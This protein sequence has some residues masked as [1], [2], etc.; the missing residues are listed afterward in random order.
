MS[1]RRLFHNSPTAAAANGTI[2]NPSDVA[3]HPTK[4]YGRTIKRHEGAPI[5]DHRNKWETARNVKVIVKN[6]TPI[7]YPGYGRIITMDSGIYPKQKTYIVA[8]CDFPSCTCEDFVTMSSGA[9]GKRKAW[10]NC[11]HLYYVY[12]FLC[13]ANSMDDKYIHAPSLSFDEV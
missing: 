2:L 13:K 1:P 5:V 3:A 4:R 12:R 9:L 10:V 7:P 11:K 8:L 6:V